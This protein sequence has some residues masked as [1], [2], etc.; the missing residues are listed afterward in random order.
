LAEHTPIL[1]IRWM[2]PQKASEVTPGLLMVL[3]ALKQRSAAFRHLDRL[4]VDHPGREVASR[5]TFSRR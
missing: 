5:P 1:N 2:K 3:P 4:D